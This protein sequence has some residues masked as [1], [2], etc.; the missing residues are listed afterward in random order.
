MFRCVSGG[1]IARPS[2]TTR[3]RAAQRGLT[4]LVRE[5]D[6]AS[7]FLDL[8]TDGS[9]DAVF[10]VDPDR[11]LL[12]FNRRG[13]E[14]TGFSREEVLG[15]NCLSAFR[16]PRCLEACRV[17]ERGRI[18]AA[19]VEIFRKDETR[20][21]VRKRAAVLR[22]RLGRTIGAVEIFR[23]AEGGQARDAASSRGA[24]VSWDGAESL[25]SSL[26]RGLVVVDREFI[27][28]RVSQNF[29][30]LAGRR[31]GELESTAAAAVLGGGLFEA[32]SPFARAL[33][34]GQRREGWRGSV[35]ATSG[36]RVRVSVTGA[37][38]PSSDQC[39][40]CVEA[41]AFVLVVRPD[42][43]DASVND[44]QHAAGFEGLV[45]RSAA[46][47]RVF[48]LVDHLR[49]SDAT[50]LVTGESGTGKELVAR[51]I[52]A[53]SRRAERPF[54]A[55]NCGA[56]PG[57]LLESELFGHVRGAFTGAGWD[58]LGRFEVVEDGTLFLD[59]IGDLPVELQVKLL[60]VLQERQ[61]ERVGEVRPRPFR[62][63]VVAATHHDLA[64]AVAGKTFREDLFYRLNVVPV[65]LPPLRERRED[66]ELL[67]GHV[68]E[69]IGERR[70]R[71][72]RLSPGAMR[73]LL[74]CDWPGNVRQLENALECAT[75]V[76]EGQTIHVEDLPPE[77]TAADGPAARAGADAVAGAG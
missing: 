74:A 68:L 70:S 9:S 66:L 72:L 21:R 10:V 45:G 71:L 41:A 31:A 59:E 23:E 29:A 56:L 36:A 32:D 73:A 25:M 52:H 62:A 51:A 67:I 35:A 37:P 77:I 61:F 63:R 4:R 19:S 30:E 57:S 12:L 42:P 27:I 13:E 3:V 55:V 34:D 24:Q 2:D 6:G 11:N 39:E 22:D 75:A 16:C 18:G 44:P 15:R 47:Q 48:N 1:D 69:R 5:A 40:P 54:V 60:R 20:L 46:M 64:R 49:D 28:R 76:C 17:F 58:K 33:L 50:V 8:V 7:A 26:G 65:R 53:R 14:I 38:I 43:P